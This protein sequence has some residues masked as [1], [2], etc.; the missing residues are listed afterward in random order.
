[1]DKKYKIIYSRQFKIKGDI[2]LKLAAEFFGKIK[3]INDILRKRS[4]KCIA[5][6]KLSEF[7][8][9]FGSY[10]YLCSG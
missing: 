4:N 7:Q 1:V 3:N 10:G 2:V 6:E 5:S 9:C 8:K